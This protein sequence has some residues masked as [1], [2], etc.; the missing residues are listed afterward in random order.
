MV[1][2]CALRYVYSGRAVNVKLQPSHSNGCCHGTVTKT[3]FLT[4]K[5]KVC[6]I[7][8]LRAKASATVNHNDSTGGCAR[9][10]LENSHQSTEESSISICT[11]WANLEE[12]RVCGNVRP[13]IVIKLVSLRWPA[14][15]GIAPRCD[16]GV[17]VAIIIKV[18]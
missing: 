11:H 15:R 10:G 9:P 17:Q 13:V 2:L 8:V 6:I 3:G 12:R 1:I 16:V 18:P 14:S 7:A 5:S 4:C